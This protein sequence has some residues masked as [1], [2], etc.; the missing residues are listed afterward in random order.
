M[1]QGDEPRPVRPRLIMTSRSAPRPTWTRSARVTSSTVSRCSSSTRVVGFPR[2]GSRHCLRPSA[3]RGR[4]RDRRPRRGGRRR[5]PKPSSTGSRTADRG[6]SRHGDVAA[7]RLAVRER[8]PGRVRRRGPPGRPPA[9]SCARTC[10]E[11]RPHRC[12]TGH[13][14]RRVIGVR[15]R[16]VETWC[17]P[18]ARRAAVPF[19]PR[20]AFVPGIPCRHGARRW[21][22]SRSAGGD[23][24]VGPVPGPASRGVRGL[25]HGHP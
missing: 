14:R 23:C 8:V 24:G 18:G 12:R 16:A 9:T 13:V 25:L 2:P 3:D 11:P 1:G 15:N 17:S 4:G 10:L 21:S 5:R 7:P 19:K 22:P 20:D 6:S